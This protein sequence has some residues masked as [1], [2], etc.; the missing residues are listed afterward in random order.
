MFYKKEE[1]FI[2]LRKSASK[3]QHSS[4]LAFMI[5]HDS[6]MEKNNNNSKAKTTLRKRR[7]IFYQYVYFAIEIIF[8]YSNNQKLKKHTHKIDWH[9]FIILYLHENKGEVSK[10]LN[11]IYYY[12][13]LRFDLEFRL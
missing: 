8:E 10:H 6:K 3:Q 4:K 7:S 2:K 9:N 1:T 11:R 13:V 12:K 5:D